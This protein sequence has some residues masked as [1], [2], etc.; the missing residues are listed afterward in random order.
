[1]Q[2]IICNSCEENKELNS[3]MFSNMHGLSFFG[4]TS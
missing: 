2:R 4:I 3:Q 1:M